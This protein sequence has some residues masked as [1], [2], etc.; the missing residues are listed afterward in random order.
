MSA[1]ASTKKAFIVVETPFWGPT[2]SLVVSAA[3]ASVEF[4]RKH[5]D[6]FH[7]ASIGDL[8]RDSAGCYC[9]V[10]VAYFHV[11]DRHLAN[12]A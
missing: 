2:E 4:Y 7:I 3:A 5:C 8:T 12:A 6:N 11:T 9:V 10:V 1:A